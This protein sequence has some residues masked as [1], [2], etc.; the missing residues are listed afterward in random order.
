VRSAV[1]YRYGL[2]FEG[3][4]RNYLPTTANVPNAGSLQFGINIRNFSLGPMRVRA[5]EIDIRIGSRASPKLN[6][7]ELA[8]G[9]LSRG[10]G[11]TITPAAFAPE[12]LKE[13]H[14]VTNVEGTADFSL[15]Y[16]HP[17]SP[18]E[19]RLR[20]TLA[21][22]LEFAEDGSRLAYSDNIIAEYDEPA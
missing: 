8:G 22:Y 5:E 7:G 3:I 21:L 2:I 13:F 17:D 16:G 6:K 15:V 12:Q 4:Q 9:I 14:G 10:A 19:R 20:M 18:P 1:D 11:R